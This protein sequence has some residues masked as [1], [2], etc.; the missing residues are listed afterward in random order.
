M[1]NAHTIMLKDKER[2]HYGDLGGNSAKMYLREKG[3]RV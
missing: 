3:A 1:R 2:G